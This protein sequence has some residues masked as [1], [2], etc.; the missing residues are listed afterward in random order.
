MFYD[1][2]LF[3]LNKSILKNKKVDTVFAYYISNIIVS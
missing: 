3:L 1:N 2:S